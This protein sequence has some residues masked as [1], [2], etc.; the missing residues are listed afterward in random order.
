MK[1]NTTPREQLAIIAEM[2]E[3]TRRDTA[4]SGRFFIFTGIVSLAGTIAVGLLESAGIQRL[5]L[6]VFI[7][8][9]LINAA[10]GYLVIAGDQRRHA[11]KSYAKTVLWQVWLIC[12]LTA[13]LMMFAFPPLNICA[14][15]AVPVLIS[16]VLG[17]AVYIS[18]IVLALPFLQWSCLAWFGGAII[19][20]A[21]PGESVVYIMAA[22]I[23]LGWITP[24]LHLNRRF[25]E[26][27]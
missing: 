24:G 15:G 8:L 22:M 12:G 18:G 20:A 6:P 1:E 19:I 13:L 9:A 11:V 2:V 10:I 23:I 7:L 17:I 5:F 27:S 16:F 14:V 21:W 3:K 25:K 4:E 26:R